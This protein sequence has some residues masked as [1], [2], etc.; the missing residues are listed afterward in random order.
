MDRRLTAA[1]GRVA[2][3]HLQGQVQADHYTAGLPRRTV[4]AVTDLRRSPA[5]PRDRQLLFGA[6]V[7]AFEDQAGWSFV[8]QDRDG[9]VGYVLTHALGPALAPTHHVATAAT[10]L[11]AAEDYKSPD[12]MALSFGT[13]VTVTA[14]RRRFWET[15]D[16]YIPKPHLWPLDKPFADPVTVAQLHF[17]V[18][19][20]WGGNSVRGIDC[21]GL[22]QAAVSACGLPC[23]A[24]SDMQRDGLGTVLA[25][26]APPRRGD[27]WFW[28][29][30][31][32]M[33]VDPDTLIHA[34]AHHMAV[35]Y[36][37][38]THATLRIAAQGNGGVISRKRL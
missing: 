37:P 33:V 11:Y 4:H 2:A 31:V 9:Y 32:G 34:N 35:A 24:D 5:G 19:Y 16:G 10:H 17:G 12:L 6:A 36:E 38:L 1:N 28:Q 29:G 15:P 7:T 23:P 14:E 26:D 8:Q 13:R 18:P 21:S 22:V 27:L 20:L 3:L 25:P 30:H